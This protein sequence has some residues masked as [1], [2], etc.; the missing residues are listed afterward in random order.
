MAIKSVYATGSRASVAVGEEVEYG[1]PVTPSHRILMTSESI[2]SAESTLQSNEL[3][4]ER[5]LA[6]VI[7]ASYDASGDISLEL[8]ATGHG[9]L[10]KHLLGD[11]VKIQ[12]TDGSI[13]GRQV[14]D[15]LREL[16]GTDS[17][18]DG[19]QIV[20]LADEATVPFD[21]TGTFAM[22]YRD[23]NGV[24]SVSDNGGAGH[25]YMDNGMQTYLQTSVRVNGGSQINTAD[26]TLN[27]IN[28][29]KNHA[30][31]W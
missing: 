19:N 27:I 10:Y 2:T 11:Y 14:Q 31:N 29:I 12:N 15:T 17:A 5:G 25:A 28:R 23:T 16:T 24:L 7:V 4:Q 18:E 20:I 9:I 6:E 3:T 1:S 21:A 30:D 22:A 13:R 8:N 26:N